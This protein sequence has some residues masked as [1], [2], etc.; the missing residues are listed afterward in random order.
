MFA[1]NLRRTGAGVDWVCSPPLTGAVLSFLDQ[2]TSL[3]AF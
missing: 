3:V 2:E 1:D